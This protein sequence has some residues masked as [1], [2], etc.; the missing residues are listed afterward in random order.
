M[1]FLAIEGINICFFGSYYSV[2]ILCTKSSKTTVIV[3]KHIIMEKIM[4]ML[5][6]VCWLIGDIPDY[7]GY[8]INV[9]RPLSKLTLIGLGFREQ[10]YLQELP[11]KYFNLLLHKVDMEVYQLCFNLVINLKNNI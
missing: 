2:S 1:Y 6:F 9:D 7:W 8:N 3:Q 10:L 5:V 4:Q 11:Q